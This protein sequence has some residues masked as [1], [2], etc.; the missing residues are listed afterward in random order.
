MSFQFALN[1]YRVQPLRRRNQVK[2]RSIV[3]RDTS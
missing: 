2:K 1:I 3:G